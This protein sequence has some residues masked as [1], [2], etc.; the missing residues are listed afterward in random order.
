MGLHDVLVRP[1]IRPMLAFELHWNRCVS[2]LVREDLLHNLLH[3]LVFAVIRTRV[4]GIPH[5]LWDYL[6]LV[7]TLLGFSR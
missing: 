4:D 2:F 1:R 6:L 3:A 7:S 5:Q